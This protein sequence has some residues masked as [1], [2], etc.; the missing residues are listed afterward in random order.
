MAGL[1]RL[2]SHEETADLLRVPPATLHYMNYRGTGPRSYKVGRY[3]RYAPDDIRVWLES[4]ASAGE[5]AP[6]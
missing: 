3:R 1:Q 4:Q 6:E 5:A 2:L